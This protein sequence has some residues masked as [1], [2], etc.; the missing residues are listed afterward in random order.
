MTV[1]LT[2]T[3]Y[4]YNFSSLLKHVLKLVGKYRYLFSCEWEQYTILFNFKDF[5]IRNILESVLIKNSFNDTMNLNHRFVFLIFKT[6]F[7]E[8]E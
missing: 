1:P 5:Y 4:L 2:F 8:K 7:Y 3:N 6:F